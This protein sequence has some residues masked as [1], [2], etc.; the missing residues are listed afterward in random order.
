MLAYVFQQPSLSLSPKSTMVWLLSSR[1]PVVP[2]SLLSGRVRDRQYLTVEEVASMETREVRT[3]VPKLTL[4]I[5]VAE[6]SVVPNNGCL[7]ITLVRSLD[8]QKDRKI[9]QTRNRCLIDEST[10]VCQVSANSVSGVPDSLACLM[11]YS[12]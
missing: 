6:V 11:R 12:K 2:P 1:P 7:K 10:A 5:I 9:R 4:I 3:D 8:A